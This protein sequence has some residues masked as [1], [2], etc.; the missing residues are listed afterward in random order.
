ML[1]VD[2]YMSEVGLE[3]RLRDLRIFRIFEGTNDI[4]R[5]FIALSGLQFA[6]NN[7]RQIVKNVTKNPLAHPD[8][9]VKEGKKRT[10][11]LLGVNSSGAGLE[12]VVHPDLR[13]SAK[14]IGKAVDSFGVGS[15]IMLRKYGKGVVDEQFRLKRIADCLI[16]LYASACVLARASKAIEEGTSTADHQT[17]MTRL[18]C[19][20]AY[21]RIM[22]NLAAIEGK[23]GEVNFV[24]MKEISENV[25]AAGGVVQNHPVGV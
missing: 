9:I 23:N 3:K 1:G 10:L 21:D 2:G 20:A 14:K 19:D 12:S 16:D 5:L 22:D 6:G 17:M 4:L 15:E 11:R 8:L 24:R 18:W 7:L 25:V 13:T